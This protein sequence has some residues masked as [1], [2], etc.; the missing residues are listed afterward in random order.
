MAVNP[1]ESECTSQEF[2]ALIT[3]PTVSLNPGFDTDLC[4][5]KENSPNTNDAVLGLFSLLDGETGSTASSSC[6]GGNESPLIS[7]SLMAELP[8]IHYTSPKCSQAMYPIRAIPSSN[9]PAGL[10][11]NQSGI[12][13]ESVR[14][15]YSMKG[16]GQQSRIALSSAALLP[17]VVQNA[18]DG[19]SNTP[20]SQSGTFQEAL[21]MDVDKKGE[22]DGLNIDLLFENTHNAC[23]MD[24]AG[25]QSPITLPSTAVMPSVLQNGEGG[26]SN[27]PFSESRPYQEAL[28]MDIANTWE[29]NF[30]NIDLLFEN[31]PNINGNTADPLFPYFSSSL[32]TTDQLERSRPPHKSSTAGLRKETKADKHTPQVFKVGG[33]RIPKKAPQRLKKCKEPVQQSKHCHICARAVQRVNVA[34]CKN[35]RRETNSETKIC[36]KVV[37]R[38]CF[39]T[40]ES[41]GS[42]ENATR[43]RIG[44]ECLHCRLPEESSK[45]GECCPAR[46][47]CN[48]YTKSNALRRSENL[49]KKRLRDEDVERTER[50]KIQR[51]G[52][53]G[54]QKLLQGRRI[55]QASAST[56]SGSISTIL[57]PYHIDS[58]QVDTGSLPA[59]RNVRD[60]GRMLNGNWN[61]IV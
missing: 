56:V 40:L 41:E 2:E 24:G 8:D 16:T 18:K 28:S 29:S 27:T 31:T 44:W 51:L 48:I 4:G 12:K 38:K 49:K 43:S 7:T 33:A 46:A 37:C 30:P 11:Q 47:Q 36:R 1:G 25:E 10:S 20:F 32:Q 34:V 22:Y 60:L 26:P 42:F 6:L 19:P 14:E 57:L 53:V 39:G 15:D 9:Y 59:N 58:L 5:S 55:M 61:D 35:L 50:L 52:Q 3:Y 17:S 45:P 54:R 23:L 13:V 21:P